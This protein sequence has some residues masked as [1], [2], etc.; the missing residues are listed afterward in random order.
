MGVGGWAGVCVWV[1]RRLAGW[2]A[3]WFGWLVGLI[4]CLYLVFVGWLVGWL[5]GPIGR[6]ACF[7]WCGCRMIWF[8]VASG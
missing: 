1:G 2:V 7:A 6:L 8:D 5:V 3:G 4:D